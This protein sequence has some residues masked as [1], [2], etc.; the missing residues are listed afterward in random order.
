MVGR[1]KTPDGSASGGQPTGSDADIFRQALSAHQ[2][3]DNSRAQELCR[4]IVDRHPDHADSLHLLGMIAA[5]EGHREDAARLLGRAVALD[6]T[7]PACHSNLA[8]VLRDLGRLAD[9][10]KHARQAVQLAKGNVTALY[11]LGSILMAQGRHAEAIDIMRRVVASAPSHPRASY[12]LGIALRATGHVADAEHALRQAIQIT[13][14]NIA[15]HSGLGEVLSIL[16]R[17]DEAAE[18]LAAGLAINPRHVPT[19]INLA[20]ALVS[21]GNAGQAVEHYLAALK[22][23][24]R[25]APAYYGLIVNARQSANDEQ[26]A[27]MQTLFADESTAPMDKILLGFSLSRAMETNARHDEAFEYAGQA[28]EL[29]KDH[30]RKHGVAF[31]PQKHIALV[32]GIVETF[33]SSFF[34]DRPGWGAQSDTPVFVVGMPR[35]GTTLV[36]QIIASHPDCAGAGELPDIDNMASRLPQLLRTTDHY[37]QCAAQLTGPTATRLAEQYLRRLATVGVGAVRVIDKMTINFLHLGLI[38]LLLP[39]AKII[40]CTRDPRDICTSCYFQNFN[41]AG[42]AFTFDLEHLGVFY[43]QYERLMT[44]WRETLPLDI[45]EVPYEQLLA[46]QEGVSR[47]MIDFCGLPWNEQ[48]LEFHRNT[49]QVRTSSALQVRRPI[50]KTSVARWKNYEAQLGPFLQQLPTTPNDTA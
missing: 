31:T 35:S 3:G 4:Q 14:D 11:N 23:A 41:E 40:H 5:I 33:T 21:L 15:A 24:P 29:K 12:D 1:D 7:N 43:A 19:L 20:N 45:H 44:H 42:L 38:A 10:E 26:S 28:N 6:D 49:R 27:S 39:R 47:G 48:C 9:A 34:A 16:G 13:P 50:Y 25:F 8:A 32:D 37:P 2:A 18:I 30:Y 22:I 36:E 46:D 17:A